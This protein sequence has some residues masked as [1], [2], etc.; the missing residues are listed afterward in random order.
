MVGGDQVLLT[1]S[2]V[3]L[4]LLSN[5]TALQRIAHV[6]RALSGAPRA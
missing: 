4:A 1:V 2:I 3:V 6:S 5:L